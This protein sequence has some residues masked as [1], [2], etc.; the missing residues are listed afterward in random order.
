M[1]TLFS[2]LISTERFVNAQIGEEIQDIIKECQKIDHR[3]TIIELKLRTIE[4]A[5][6]R[7]PPPE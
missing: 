5:A 2:K 1:K 4:N 7:L 6:D 3:Y